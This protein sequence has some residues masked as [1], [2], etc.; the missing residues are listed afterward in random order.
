MIWTSA[1]STRA[2]ACSVLRAWAGA[3]GCLAGAH[4]P[5]VARAQHSTARDTHTSTRADWHSARSALHRAMGDLGVHSVSA[6]GF[7]LQVDDYEQGRPSYPQQAVGHALQGLWHG[8]DSSPKAVL[9]QSLRL[10][11]HVITTTLFFTM[12]VRRCGCRHWEVHQVSQP[13][14]TLWPYA[15]GCSLN[16]S[17][18]SCRLL[19]EHPLLAVTALEPNE[20]MRKGFEEA[21]TRWNLTRPISCHP[22]NATA[23][24]FDDA[25]FD[26]V[27]VAQV[28][29]C[30]LF[31]ASLKHLR[32]PMFL[33]AFHWFANET[34]LREMHRVLRPQGLLVSAAQSWLTLAQSAHL[35]PCWLQVLLWNRE[36]EDVPWQKQLLHFFEP[37]STGVPQYWQGEEADCVLLRN[38]LTGRAC[39]DVEA[40]L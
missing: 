16:A 33:Q 8:G 25:S 32:E 14:S 30:M 9:G 35:N 20:G 12:L 34:A 17:L 1:R 31:L 5:A 21:Q 11:D 7:S 40:G 22:G 10:I 37:L 3:I 13:T 4:K 24:P 39:R 19:A 28:A 36:D 29:A 26:A 23:L 2:I 38:I 27:T 6:S 15:A 18:R